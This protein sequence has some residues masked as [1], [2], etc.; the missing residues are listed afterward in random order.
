M[1]V[2]DSQWFLH[3]NEKPGVEWDCD[4]K[5]ENEFMIQLSDM[6]RKNYNKLVIMACHH[7]F[8]SNGVHGG[9]YGLKQHIF[10]FTDMKKNLWIPLPVIGSIYSHQ[11]WCIWQSTGHKLSRLYQ[12]GK[13]HPG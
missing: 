4:C 7:P 12:Y 11:P 9:Y 5:T 13:Y 8:M 6:L 2:F 1:I 3:Q 10:P